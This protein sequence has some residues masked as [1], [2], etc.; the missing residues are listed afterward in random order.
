MSGIKEPAES[1]E[2]LEDGTTF[3]VTE[4]GPEDQFLLTEGWEEPNYTQVP[5]QLLGHWDGN[6]NF[7][8]GQ[9]TDMRETELKV[10]LVLC[11]ITFGFHREGAAASLSWLEKATGLS[12]QGVLDG[13][14]ALIKRG[15]FIKDKSKDGR[16]LWRQV[17]G[18]SLPSRPEVVNGVDQTSLLGRPNKERLKKER[19]KDHSPPKKQAE[20]DIQE[21]EYVDLDDDGFP[22][23]PVHPL[24]K[25]IQRNTGRKLTPNQQNKLTSGVPLHNPCHP[26]PCTLFEH[27]PRFEQ[28]ID[29]KIAWA[30]GGIDGQRRQTGSLIT[31]IRN[32]DDEHY[33]W[34]NFAQKLEEEARASPAN[35]FRPLEE[36]QAKLIENQR[37]AESGKIPDPGAI[38]L[39]D[40]MVVRTVEDPVVEE[41]GEFVRIDMQALKREFEEKMREGER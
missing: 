15:L 30:T 36:V 20:H 40:G 33:G 22:S 28:Y 23:K 3:Q 6:G 1:Y 18:G 38:K 26:S 7:I 9:L 27:D 29:G 17:H 41:G 10:A 21:T 37:Q 8:L 16:N 32:Y 35:Q 19:K 13:I 31:A 14:A 11:R 2:T 39:A 25:Y 34:L 12:R 5:N 24:V 4:Y